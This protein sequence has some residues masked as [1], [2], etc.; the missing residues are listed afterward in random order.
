MIKVL[1]LATSYANYQYFLRYS[2]LTYGETRFVSMINQAMGW[3]SKIPFV[4]VGPHDSHSEIIRQL[5]LNRQHQELVN[6]LT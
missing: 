5:L 4:T 2:G 1:V 3:D 6:D